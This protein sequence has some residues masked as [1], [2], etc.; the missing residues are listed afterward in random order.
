[1]EEQKQKIEFECKK[2]GH[3]F[4]STMPEKP[5]NYSVR[6]PKC[7]N[8]IVFEVAS[9]EVPEQPKEQL[10]QES[11]EQPK[12]PELA[13]F[14]CPWGC[15]QQMKFKPGEDGERYVQCR[16]KDCNKGIKITV[17]N[18][19]VVNVVKAQEMVKCPWDNCGEEIAVDT[20]KDGESTMTCPHCNQSVIFMVKNHKVVEIKPN[21]TI[22]ITYPVCGKAQLRV[23][24]LL[25]INAKTY[26]LIAGRYTIG[27]YDESVHSDIEFKDDMT[28]S[29]RSVQ[30]DVKSNDSGSLS[31]KLTVL[32]C[33]NPVYHNN[34]PLVKGESVYLNYGDTIK[35]GKTTLIFEKA[36]R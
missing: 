8:K 4:R 17:A 19:K 20:V 36:K 31:Y 5:G 29:R 18:G 7:D 1:M 21:G 28:M 24:K 35:L 11:K 25:N 9:Q 26:Q 14:K 13:S 27:R 12:Q 30:I 33:M 23:V 10:K 32:K 15:G 34:K 6:C 22:I 2:C 16:N 3:K